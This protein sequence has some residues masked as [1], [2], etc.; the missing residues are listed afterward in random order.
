MRGEEILDLAE[1][2]VCVPCIFS[3]NNAKYFPLRYGIFII[4]TFLAAPLIHPRRRET[5]QIHALFK[6]SVKFDFYF[7]RSFED[8]LP[9]RDIRKCVSKTEFFKNTIAKNVLFFQA[10]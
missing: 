7:L 1:S 8:D 5:D 10:Y 2:N 9:P 6:G 4:V 3:A